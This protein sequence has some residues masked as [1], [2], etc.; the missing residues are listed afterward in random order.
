M[1]NCLAPALPLTPETSILHLVF[2][3]ASMGAL[4][5]IFTLFE[6]VEGE[7]TMDEDFYGLHPDLL[8]RSLR[9]L[10]KAGK[11]VVFTLPGATEG[12]VKFL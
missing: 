9:L 12:G 10:E 4:G 8:L 7:E 2:Q 5:T 6:I 3:A 1:N 11:C